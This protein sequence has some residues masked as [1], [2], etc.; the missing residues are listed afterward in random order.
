METLR[1]IVIIA[2]FL[3]IAISMLDIISSGEKLKK[4]MRF[5][6]SLVFMIAIISSILNSKVEFN[7]PTVKDIEESEE[8]LAVSKTYTQFLADSFKTNIEKNIK[9]K[10]EVN[11]INAKQ[12]SLI[13]DISDEDEISVNG[14]DLILSSSEYSK[15]EQ[16]IAV[17]QNEIG[18]TNVNVS[19]AE[20]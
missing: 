10:L 6:F 13:V 11:K 17:V 7:I 14:A 4:Q 5:I 16:A 20:E 15:K 1:N 2:T 12:V 18:S 3:G 8:Y 9:L 19:F